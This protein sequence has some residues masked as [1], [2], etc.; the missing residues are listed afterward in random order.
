MRQP[1]RQPHP[2]RSLEIEDFT[3][4]SN[5]VIFKDGARTK[6]MNGATG[7]IESVNTD[8]STVIQYAVDAVQALRGGIVHIK[9]GSYTISSTIQLYANA[10]SWRPT[11]LRGS[12]ILATE[13]KLG[14]DAD[15]DII[16][17]DVSGGNNDG[18]HRISDMQLDGNKANNVSGSGIVS[19]TTGAGTQ[20]DFKITDVFCVRCSEYG[21]YINNGWGTEISDVIT[22]YNDGIGVYMNGSQMY[23]KKVFSAY[24]GGE[25]MQL[26]GGDS[27]FIQLSAYNNG[28][29]GINVTNLDYGVIS[30]VIINTWGSETAS[31][32]SAFK[33][34][35]SSTY[36]VVTGLL[37]NGDTTTDCYKGLELDGHNNVVTGVLAFGVNDDYIESV[38]NDNRVD[39]EFANSIDDT[40]ARNIINGISPNAGVP[41]VAGDWI[42]EVRNGVI[43]RDTT[44][45]KTYIYAGAGWREI[46]AV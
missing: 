46:S 32:Y 20:Y 35:D 1:L 40:G 17:F 29:E 39:G 26:R 21:I 19:K 14:V 33:I 41:G 38:G 22:E 11:W 6:A 8:A 9:E 23:L 5:Y 44:N 18:F 7:A 43:V 4:E 31:A 3:L 15:C 42:A 10:A 34:G 28:Q 13:L 27:I 25:G 16:S 2:I 12:G 30:D 36:N 37:I 45:N 24:N